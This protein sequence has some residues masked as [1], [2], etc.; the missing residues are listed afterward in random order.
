MTNSAYFVHR[1]SHN[2]IT[3][4]NL[5]I[6]IMKFD[7]KNIIVFNIDRGLPETW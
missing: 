3:C 4:Y 7:K 6:N 5:Y 1:Y 2:V